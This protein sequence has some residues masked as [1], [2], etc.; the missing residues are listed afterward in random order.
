MSRVRF[1]LLLISA[2]NFQNWSTAADY[3]ELAPGVLI[4]QTE[5]EKY[6]Q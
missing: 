5:T 2:K 6:F 3:Q 1:G 4:S